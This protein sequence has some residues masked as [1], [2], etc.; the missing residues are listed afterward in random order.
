MRHGELDAV[1]RR[2][3]G[4][5]RPKLLL[6]VANETVKPRTSLAQ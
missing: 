1:D 4:D 6:P 5:R 2:G 3:D